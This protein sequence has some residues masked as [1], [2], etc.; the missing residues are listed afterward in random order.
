MS[1]MTEAP[2]PPPPTGGSGVPD[3]VTQLL[4]RWSQGDEA[5]LARMLPLVYDELRRMAHRHLQ[6]ERV[7]HTLQRTGLVHEAYLRLAQQGPLQW[8]SRAHFFGW[9]STLMRHILIDHARSRQSAKRGGGA[10][11]LSLD[12]MQD[13]T[14]GVAEASAP[15][16]S[17]DLIALDHALK[18]L[19]QLDPQQSRVVELRFFGGLS[20][21]ETAEA[22]EISAATVK[23][24]WATARAWLLREMGRLK[25]PGA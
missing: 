15:E 3:E 6:R 20:V 19:E 16:D 4:K 25:D 11:L 13:S 7:G 22:L 24:E 5:A 17:L 1:P 9:A 21:V 2:R 8:K 10:A 12:A 23:R 14:G 18:R